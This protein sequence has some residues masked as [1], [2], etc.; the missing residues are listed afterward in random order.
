MPDRESIVIAV[1]FDGTVVDHRYPDVG[2]DAPGAVEVLQALIE[3]GARIIL[4]TMR[5]GPHLADAMAWFADHNIPLYGVQRNP[6]QDAWTDSPKAYAHVYIDDAAYG[7]PKVHPE[8]FSRPCVDWSLV[9]KTLC[10][11]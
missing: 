7:C 2:A 10:G 5:S 3:N 8:G 1:D 11:E 9:L 4:W 6:S